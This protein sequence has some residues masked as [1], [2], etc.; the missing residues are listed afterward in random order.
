MVSDIV[1]IGFYPIANED[2][3]LLYGFDEFL[4]HDR[5]VGRQPYENIPFPIPIKCCID[6]SLSCIENRADQGRSER[7]LGGQDIEGGKTCHWFSSSEG[8]S[9]YCAYPDS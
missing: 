7:D 5:L 8:Q 1:S 3:F 6:F 4:R 9:L 2:R